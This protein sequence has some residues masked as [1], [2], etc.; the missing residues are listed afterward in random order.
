MYLL[1]GGP[2]LTP[3][4][5]PANR[6]LAEEILEQARTIKDGYILTDESN[7]PMRIFPGA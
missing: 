4:D 3:V 6:G 1:Y 2:R 7:S 5:S